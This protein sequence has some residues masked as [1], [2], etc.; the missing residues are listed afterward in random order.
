MSNLRPDLP[1]GLIWIH[2]VG[3]DGPVV[4][5][6]HVSQWSGRVRVIDD[7]DTEYPYE[8]GWVHKWEVYHAEEVQR[9]DPRIPPPR[10]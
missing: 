4:L 7:A 8:D 3:P 1:Y 6:C 2:A 9:P 5:L 10:E